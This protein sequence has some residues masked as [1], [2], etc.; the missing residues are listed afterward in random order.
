MKTLALEN[1]EP[2]GIHVTIMMATF[3]GPGV[4]QQAVILQSSVSVLAHREGI[5]K[6]RKYIWHLKKNHI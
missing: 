5:N 3:T 2:C 1:L 4:Q 6:D